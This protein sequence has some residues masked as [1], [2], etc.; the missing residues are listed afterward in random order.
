MMILTLAPAGSLEAAAAAILKNYQLTLVESKK[1]TV[2]GLPAMV[3]VADQSAQDQQ[4]SLRTLIYVIAHGKNNYAMIGVSGR[5][6]F[7]AYAAT[8]QGSMERFNELKD[9][10]KINK[11]AERIRIKTVQRNATLAE[12]LKGHGTPDKRMEELAIL[13]GMNLTDKVT[14]GMLIKTIGE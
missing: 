2:N 3:M 1:H 13:N 14:K 8:F 5:S 10:E 7:D 6:T 12:A 9:P 4:Q 11:K